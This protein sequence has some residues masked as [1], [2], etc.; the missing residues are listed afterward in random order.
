MDQRFRTDRVWLE[1][2]G[3]II[4]VVVPM[5]CTRMRLVWEAAQLDV[6]V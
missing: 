1:A 2:V 4:K 6:D 5:G 3:A